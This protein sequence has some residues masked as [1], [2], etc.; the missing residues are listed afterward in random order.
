[1]N[2]TSLEMTNNP[3]NRE[4]KRREL[5]SFSFPT[6]IMM[7]VI[8]T[9]SILDVALISRLVSLDSM[10]SANIAF[11]VTGV[12]MGVGIMLGRGGSACVAK[13]MGEDRHKEAC[14]DFSFL[15]LC[16]IL[17]GLLVA[18]LGIFFAKEI[19]LLLGA[20][21]VLLADTVTYLRV[22]MIFSPLTLLQLMF[23]SFYIT[24]GKGK[25]GMILMI[26][27]GI[28]DAVLNI[29]FMGFLQMGILGAALSTVI[30]HSI[31]ALVGMWMFYKRKEGLRFLKPSFDKKMLKK[32]CS[33]GSAELVTNLSSGFTTFLF[34]SVMMRF[35][36]EAG[37]SA[38][39]IITYT[40]FFL[41]SIYIGFSS[42][43]A[44]V[45]SFN[46][47]AKKEKRIQ[48]LR[49]ESLQIITAMSLII[50]VFSLLFSKVIVGIFAG[51]SDLV[52]E[53][54]EKGM[55][56]LAVSFLFT[57][58]NTFASAYFSA[59]TKGK[60][61]AFLSTM[62]KLVFLVAGI[63]LFPLV[64]GSNGVWMTILGAELLCAV[65]CVFLFR[66]KWGS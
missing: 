22:L 40:Q 47:G 45:F 3:L 8:S 10:A 64:M 14:S 59:M 61:S 27:S 54:A 11:P 60:L 24:A 7:L 16:G 4:F 32:S 62:R 23:Q 6:I 48:H 30:G 50:T 65:M 58:L 2:E 34:N 35:H 36:G 12:L 9:Y 39:T 19:A 20:N 29:V 15:V 56:F 31:S 52:Y 37:V 25:L 28:T 38:I 55:K 26:I 18:V 42:G 5:L 21:E 41:S 44:P 57:G 13:K 1:M 66:S 43:V 33:Y 46:L 17:I 63:L 49:K 51:P 53:L